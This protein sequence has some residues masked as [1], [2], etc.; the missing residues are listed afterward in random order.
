[1]RGLII[2]R[3]FHNASAIV[4]PFT[5]ESKLISLSENSNEYWV[6]LYE[7][8]HDYGYM[9]IDKEHGHGM[10]ITKLIQN[11]NLEELERFLYKLAID[12]IPLNE[13]LALFKDAYQHGY[14]DGKKDKGIEIHKYIMDL[15]P[16]Y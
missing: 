6:N 8:V 3:S 7:I 1:M 10:T 13:L 4:V 16:D 9:H 15:N 5:I 14:L 2:G 11:G 12:Q